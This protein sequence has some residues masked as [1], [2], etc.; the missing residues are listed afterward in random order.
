MARKNQSKLSPPARSSIDFSSD[1]SA[2]FQ[3][4]DR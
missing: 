2:A 4:P 3:S 1:A